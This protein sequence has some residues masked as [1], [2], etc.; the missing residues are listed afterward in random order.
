MIM[1]LM[2]ELSLIKVTYWASSIL[3][4]SINQVTEPCNPE[5][6]ILASKRLSLISAN[7][8]AIEKWMN[9]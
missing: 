5:V 4:P 8:G 3:I 1:A 7:V 6:D 9:N 2:S